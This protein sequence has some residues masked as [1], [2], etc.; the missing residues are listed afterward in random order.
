MLLLCGAV[1][2]AQGAFLSLDSDIVSE[3]GSGVAKE[4]LSIHKTAT[5]AGVGLQIEVES[6]GGEA[7]ERVLAQ[8][9]AGNAV[10]VRQFK[11]GTRTATVVA[12]MAPAG[13]AVS[14]AAVASRDGRSLQY[15]RVGLATV[16]VRQKEDGSVEV[17][18]FP[19]S[20]KT[21]PRPAVLTQLGEEGVEMYDTAQVDMH[22]GL[23]RPGFAVKLH[24]RGAGTTTATTTAT[25]TTT[26]STT[27]TSATAA[28][29]TTTEEA[30]LTMPPELR[31][32]GR[33]ID[34]RRNRRHRQRSSSSKRRRRAKTEEEE[35]A[36]QASDLRKLAALKKHIEMAEEETDA[37][38]PAKKGGKR[39]KSSRKKK[40]GK[41][42]DIE[43][44][45]M[46]ILADEPRHKPVL[47][48]DV[49]PADDLTSAKHDADTE[50]PAAS[51][52]DDV[53]GFALHADKSDKKRSVA[54]P[55]RDEE[56]SLDA[57]IAAAEK[58]DAV[59]KKPKRKEQHL[60][61]S[62]FEEAFSKQAEAEKLASA[63]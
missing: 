63:N 55:F 22:T 32:S 54:V 29:T 13:S 56:G 40:T 5:A 58:A 36:V 25:T 42:N 50:E 28:P 21:E 43:S 17:V 27:T 38:T 41:L 14:H 12:V 34:A 37:P 2:A 24:K 30:A 33:H 8:G 6:E 10:T 47:L 57:Q 1:W 46:E 59:T 52:F 60:P 61:S 20:G 4:R 62:L 19:D 18:V 31:R 15:I 53:A 35:Q 23:L 11:R 39:R 44:M 48:Q 26:T 45:D 3:A 16:E 49:A 9:V 7:S 51:H